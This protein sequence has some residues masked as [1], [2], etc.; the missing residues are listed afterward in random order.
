MGLLVLEYHLFILTWKLKGWKGAIASDIKENGEKSSLIC[1]YSKT[2]MDRALA[3]GSSDLYLNS[4][5]IFLAL[6][7]DFSSVK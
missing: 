1:I 5:C 6:W 2:I 4:G 3:L 7:I